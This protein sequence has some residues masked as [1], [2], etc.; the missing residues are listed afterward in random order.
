MINLDFVGINIIKAPINKHKRPF[1]EYVKRIPRTV[2]KV[3]MVII[4]F[5]KVRSL[6]FKKEA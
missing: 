2:N 1:L 3:S 6:F 5:V 4:I